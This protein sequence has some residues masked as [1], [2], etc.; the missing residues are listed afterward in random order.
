[1]RC[2]SIL[3]LSISA[4]T[5][6]VTETKQAPKLLEGAE[7]VQ[8]LLERMEREE[9]ALQLR[10]PELV[11]PPPLEELIPQYKPR[12]GEKVL[13]RANGSLSKFFSVRAG[14]GAQF[15]GLLLKYCDLLEAAVELIDRADIESFRDPRNTPAGPATNID[16]SDWIVVT[17]TEA[18]VTRAEKFLDQYYASIPQIEIEAKIAE[19]TSD[20][21]KDLGVVTDI[22]NEVPGKIVED[23]DSVTAGTQNPPPNFDS[24]V[25]QTSTNFPNTATTSSGTPSSILLRAIL[26]KTELKAALQLLAT[27]RNVDIVSS[28]RIAVRNGGKA[29]I[30]NGEEIPFVNITS[31]SPSQTTFSG[32]VQYRQTGVKLY[33]VP[34]LASEDMIFLNVEAE[35]STPSGFTNVGGVS[36]PIIVTRNA[37]TDVHIREGGTFVIGGLISSSETELT[38]KVPILGDIP[39]IGLLF[40]SN[41]KQKVYTEV[42]FF[43][44]PRVISRESGQNQLLIP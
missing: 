4:L 41:Y 44:T 23:I 18:E 31:F 39:L 42:L 1:M 43:I 19:V 5:G 30:V 21:V 13:L 11:G 32:S 26:G 12:P 3:V 2:P 36:N 7:S 14:R 6:C 35:V 34:Y 17:G 9:A 8:S 15:R 20:N 27:Q 16:I 29:E 24:V 38:R 25:S 28:P 40:R 10:E 33:I 22:F 37:K